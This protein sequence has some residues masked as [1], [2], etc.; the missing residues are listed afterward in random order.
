MRKVLLAALIGG[1]ALAGTQAQALSITPGSSF[2]L[3]T[4]TQTGQAQIDTAIALYLG[5]AT[6]LYKQDVGGSE[7]GSLAGSYATTFQPSDANPTGATITYTG[8]QIVAPPS[9]LLV[10][11]GN[12]IPAWYLF[13]LAGPPH[14]G[15]N[16]ATVSAGW[17]GMEQLVLTGFWEGATG[18]ISHVALYG[19][20][21]RPPDFPAP[22]P[23]TMLLL[24][25]GLLGLAGVS[26]RKKK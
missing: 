18:S 10:K 16:P 15:T 17:D 7:S 6:E 13:Y 22:E 19:T 1:L 20:P 26:R 2:L 11:D 25:T 21:R 3:A 5:T 8:G 23:G 4:G 14:T 24:G 12:Q 9:Y